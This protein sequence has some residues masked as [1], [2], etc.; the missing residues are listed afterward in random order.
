M[1]L[2][3]KFSKPY[4]FEEK[5]YTEVDLSGLEDLKASDL[6]EADKIFIADGQIAAMNEMSVGYSCIIAAKAGSKP[7]EFFRNLPAKDA[8]TVKNTV[9]SFFYE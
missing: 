5:E 8:L 2:I 3:I 1:N 7:I 4:T 6:I 9:T